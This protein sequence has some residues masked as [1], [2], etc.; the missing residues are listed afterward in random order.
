[1]CCVGVRDAGEGVTGVTKQEHTPSAA[2]RPSSAFPAPTK[3]LSRRNK[4]PAG[5]KET[6]YPDAGDRRQEDV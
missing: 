6:E 1:V 4:Q 3:R 5:S 2:G